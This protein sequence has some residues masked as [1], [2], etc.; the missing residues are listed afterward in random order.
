MIPHEKA[1]VERLKDKP[2]AL[3]G[4]NTDSD[5]DRYLQQADELG[6]TWRSSWQGSPRGPIPTQWGVLGYPTLYL[7]DHDG[8]I[9]SSDHA[10]SNTHAKTP[11]KR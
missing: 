4:I 3:V 9:L 8:V 2:F 5:K 6:V 11:E 7:I 1:L 10:P